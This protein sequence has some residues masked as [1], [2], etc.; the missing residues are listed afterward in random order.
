MGHDAVL[1][2][3]CSKLSDNQQLM[4]SS[5]ETFKPRLST[6]TTGKIKDQATPQSSEYET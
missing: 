1:P 2:E 4:F 3:K 5:S 6:C